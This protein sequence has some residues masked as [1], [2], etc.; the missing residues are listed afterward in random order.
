MTTFTIDADNN[1]TAWDA[2]PAN[3]DGL[4]VFTTDE[5]FDAVATDWTNARF[6]E[7]WNSLTGVVPIKKFTSR[8]Y[9]INRI[10][11]QIQYLAP[12]PAPRWG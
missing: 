1:I 8:S 2:L 7:L 5:E 3:T 6:V 10:W 9:A 11:K 4:G 12:A